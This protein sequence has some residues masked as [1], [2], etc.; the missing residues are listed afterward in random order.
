MPF[1][2]GSGKKKNASLFTTKIKDRDELAEITKIAE[3]LNPDEQVLLVAKQSRIKPGGSYMTPNIVYATD[4]RI[5]I[6]DP[7]MLGLKENI[8]DIPYDI[9]TSV[10]LEKN[11][12]SSTIKFKAPGLVSSTRL[13]MM[14]EIIDGQEDEEG[15]KIESI[16]KKKAEDL[17]EIIR[18]GMQGSKKAPYTL[19]NKQEGASVQVQSEPLE[20]EGTRINNRIQSNNHS[21]TSIADELAKL[22]KL[23]DQGVITEAEFVLMKGN[24]IN[25]T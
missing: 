8:V 6:R 16:S 14:E 17:V 25:K 19:S 2:F 3:M 11:I 20:N 5:I 7:Y 10:K 9:I 12:L 21:V 23:K 13:G 4:R 18:S 22:A 24:L 1:G 15:G